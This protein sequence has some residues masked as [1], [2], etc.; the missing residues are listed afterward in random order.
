MALSVSSTIT[1]RLASADDTTWAMGNTGTILLWFKPNWSSG[2]SA[3]HMLYTCGVQS[4][5]VPSASWAFLRMEKFTDNNVY[6]GAYI[7]ATDYRVIVA[8][9]GLFTSGTW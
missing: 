6:M 3:D 7:N 4:G 9:T 1:D 5:A 2:D 8:D